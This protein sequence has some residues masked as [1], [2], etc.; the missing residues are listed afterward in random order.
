M[1]TDKRDSQLENPTSKLRERSTHVCSYVSF[2]GM[3]KLI[4]QANYKVSC[5]L[6]YRDTME[7]VEVFQDIFDNIN[8]HYG[9]SY[10]EYS[11]AP[12]R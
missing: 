9:V 3:K 11:C 8:K 5:Q 2:H 7:S 6:G 12:T 1:L 10:G 4:K